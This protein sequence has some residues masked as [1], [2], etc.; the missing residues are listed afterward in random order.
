[1]IRHSVEEKLQQTGGEGE[2][3][4]A[5]STVHH[6]GR[7]RGLCDPCF[8]ITLRRSWERVRFTETSA[9]GERIWE[10]PCCYLMPRNYEN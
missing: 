7:D 3:V 2:R 4:A 10:T 1:M 8:P 6:S 5:A 9:S